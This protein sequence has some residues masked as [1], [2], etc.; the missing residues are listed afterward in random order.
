MTE[1]RLHRI[2]LLQETRESLGRVETIARE[3][4]AFSRL[5]DG[6]GLV[7]LRAV[8]EGIL[9][10]TGHEI[11]HR[12]RLVVDVG[13]GVT[14]R[15]GEAALRHVFLNL[16]LNATQAI[17]EG[18]ASHHEIRIT[19]RRTGAEE[20]VVEIGDT[21]IGIPAEQIPRIF[22]AFFTTQPNGEGLGLG[23]AVVKD[24]VGAL[25]GR[26]D[27]DSAPGRGTRVRVTLPAAGAAEQKQASRMTTASPSRRRAL[28]IDDDRPVGAAIALELHDWD[29]L[30]AGSGREAL[31][32][33]RRDS[34]FDVV[35]CDLMMPEL[36]GMDLYEWLRPVEPGLAARFV[37]M[38]GGAFTRRAARFLEDVGAPC[39]E[40]PFPPEE[41]RATLDAVAPADA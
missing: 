21:G 7:D 3:L 27:V 36:T 37:F 32:I 25:G 18:D 26:I 22:D 28:I 14:V 9:D 12:A 40:K 33:L 16:I 29:V 38:T 19:A 24:A 39:L 4:R 1:A 13:D 23:L 35:L 5:E 6:P 17:Q 11:R 31:E 8:I 20:V 15:G 41:L 2:E 30:V 10:L 34:S